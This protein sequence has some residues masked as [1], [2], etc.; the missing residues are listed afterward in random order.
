MRR[1]SSFALLALPFVLAACAGPRAADPDPSAND[2]SA[3]WR[4]PVPIE[5][6]VFERAP[7]QPL[8]PL[9]IDE[10]PGAYAAFEFARTDGSRGVAYT[11]ATD[12]EAFGER[13]PL[14]LWCEGSGAQS[15]FGRWPQ[16]LSGGL[17]AYLVDRWGDR[18]HV[19]VCEKR[20]VDFCG[21]ADVHGSSVGATTEY[22]EHA[23]WEGRVGQN[24]ALIDALLAHP[25]VDASQVFVIGHSEGGDVAAGIASMRDE[26]TQVATLAGAGGCQWAEMMMLVRDQARDEGEDEATAEAWVASVENDLAK[27][28]ADPESTDA[29]LWGHAH[30]RWSSFGRRT[31][32]DSLLA[33]DAA[34]YMAQGTRDTAVPI[35]SFDVVVVELLRHGKRPTVVRVPDADHGFATPDD[36]EQDGILEA[37]DA[38]VEWAVERAA[39]RVA[40]RAT[41]APSAG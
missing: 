8:E 11:S 23:T 31:P 13:K 18:F 25:M 26:V 3:A 10:L 32:V 29:I 4:A 6:V 24:C 1:L 39:G 27:L 15:V 33:T 30:R 35:E 12:G 34:I 14:L 20:G 21:S 19:V 28:M 2:A 36:A 5:A 38:A 37:L 22:H 40:T 16:G 41:D 7:R 17:F 9:A